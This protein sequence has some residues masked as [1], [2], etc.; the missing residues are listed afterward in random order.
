MLTLR[1][2]ECLGRA[3]VV[4][5]DYLV[6]P[7]VL[8]HAPAAAELVCLGHHRTG[9]VLAPE[10]ITARML[11]E[12]HRGRTVVRLKG[13][14]PSVFGRGADETVGEDLADEQQPDALVRNTEGA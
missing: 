11:D 14:D 3:D 12:A 6:N 8:E 1:A 10:E 4:L 2:A 5:Y 9:R 7:A 13:G